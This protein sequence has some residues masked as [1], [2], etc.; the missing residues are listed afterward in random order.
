M[1]R[2]PLLLTAAA[3]ALGCMPAVTPSPPPV[4]PAP[5]P[6]IAID[7]SLGENLPIPPASE[8]RS[9]DDSLYYL[10]AAWSFA[11]ARNDTVAAAR[12]LDDDFVAQ[13]ADGSMRTKPGVLHD[14]S[15]GTYQGGS[16]STYDLRVQQLGDMGMV[17]SRIW[18]GRSV[19]YPHDHAQYRTTDVFVRRPDGWRLASEQMALIQPLQITTIDSIDVAYAVTQLFN[20]VRN[21]GRAHGTMETAEAP[22]AFSGEAPNRLDD[23][24]VPERILSIIDLP[25]SAYFDVSEPPIAEP[26]QPER[27]RIQMLSQEA[28]LVTF[29]VTHA[30]VVYRRTVVYRREHGRWR[31]EHVHASSV[32]MPT[33][34][35]D[36]GTLCDTTLPPEPE[37]RHRPRS[38]KIPS[39]HPLQAQ[40]GAIVGVVTERSSGRPLRDAS[41][42]FDRIVA[43]PAVPIPGEIVRTDS[44]G[45]FSTIQQADRYAV[46]ARMV[47]H[48]SEIDTITVQAG[49]VD[50]L[51]FSLRYL[52][53]AGH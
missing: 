2:S 53:C 37:T 21:F 28:A 24:G 31:I 34:R 12:I 51:R 29:E 50:T 45:G 6:R 38:A 20:A 39:P 52:S 49:R 3:L 35:A 30:H 8:W 48:R 19:T 11:V 47:L 22:S 36:I 1:N 4:P 44:L 32:R 43:P 40:T 9:V 26:F 18:W 15:S 7:S 17:V 41:V 25:R 16:M 46:R 13:A 33:A 23:Q 5:R 10:E 42:T 14:M 27:L